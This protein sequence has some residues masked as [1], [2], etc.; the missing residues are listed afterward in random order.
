[1]QKSSLSVSE[2]IIRWIYFI[3]I[4]GAW[5]NKPPCVHSLHPLKNPPSLNSFSPT[6]SGPMPTRATP[7]ALSSASS[8]LISAAIQRHIWQPNLRRKKRTTGWSLHRDWSSTLW[9]TEGTVISGR[10]RSHEFPPDLHYTPGAPH[11][12]NCIIK[13]NDVAGLTQAP[14]TRTQKAIIMC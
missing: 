3:G 1:M 4:A 10:A 5:W 2:S 11:K 14:C 9:N 12:G 7:P 13:S 8:L 6:S